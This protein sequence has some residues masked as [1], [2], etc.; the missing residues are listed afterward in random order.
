LRT[1][2]RPHAAGSDS[3]A[4]HVVLHRLVAALLQ[5]WM[6]SAKVRSRTQAVRASALSRR[7]RG[8]RR[9]CDAPD[10]RPPR[11]GAPS[12]S[13]RHPALPSNSSRGGCCRGKRRAPPWLARQHQ[14]RPRR[15]LQV[16]IAATTWRP[17]RGSAGSPAL[18]GPAHPAGRCGA[19]SWSF[20]ARRSRRKGRLQS[21]RT[22]VDARVVVE[23]AQGNSRKAPK[24][25]A[26]SQRWRKRVRRQGALA[27]RIARRPTHPC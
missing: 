22:L 8:S 15:A 17:R 25:P 18:Q 24:L 19:P 12:S 11:V 4:M 14:G 7:A 2:R 27:T 21:V 5:R 23:L 9:S 3:A 10:W 20:Q 16:E 6:S 26:A 13:H 1:V